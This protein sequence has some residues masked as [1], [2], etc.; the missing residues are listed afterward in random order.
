MK[1]T[2]KLNT[3]RSKT[4]FAISCLDHTK[5]FSVFH[6]RVKVANQSTTGACKTC[7]D[8]NI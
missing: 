1:E 3:Y 5:Q 8:E 4:H 6:K 2:L 7:L